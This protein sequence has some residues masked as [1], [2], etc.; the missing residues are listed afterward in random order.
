MGQMSAPGSPAPG[1]AARQ[2]T[3]QVCN[4]RSAGRLSNESARALK[5]LHESLARNLMNTLDVY[6]GT[7]LEVKLTS[8]EQLAME[9]YRAR[10]QPGGYVL[11]CALTP[12][13]HTM[14][15]EIDLVLLYTMIDLLLGGVGTPPEELR[16]VTEIDEE[17]IQ[18][19]SVLIAQQVE[20]AWQPIGVAVTPG[21][22]MRTTTVHK[23][24][25]PTE[26]VLRVEFE[27]GLAGVTS[28]MRIAFPASVGGHLVRNIKADPANVRGPVRYFP[29]MP[30]EERIL[31]CCFRL[32]GGLPE[33]KVPVRELAAMAVGS[34]FRLGSPVEASGRLCL[35]G[36]DFF[37]ALPV[38]AGKRKAGELVVAMPGAGQ[39]PD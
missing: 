24:F 29:R 4:F 23:L 5:T 34:V 27:V 11:P 31:D 28:A 26:K 32:S 38:R 12:A 10:L 13:S 6:L 36:K 9:D 22:P 39:P 33:V 18:G 7:A 2:R 16:E 20:R 19:V 37:E 8:L 14:L 17:I 30:L 3:I 21:M 1:Y 25:P 35:E 15:L